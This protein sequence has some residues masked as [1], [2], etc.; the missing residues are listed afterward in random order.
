MN[1]YLRK[2][3]EVKIRQFIARLKEI[4]TYLEYF[5]PYNANQAFTED[6]IKEQPYANLPSA[7]THTLRKLKHD[8]LTKSVDATV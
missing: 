1:R 4:N 8:I 3:K 7:F 2:R 6:D 5:P